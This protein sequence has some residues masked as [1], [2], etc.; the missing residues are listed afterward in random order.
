MP[1]TL[2]SILPRNPIISQ[3]VMVSHQ[4]TS[5]QRDCTGTGVSQ[6]LLPCYLNRDVESQQEILR[7]TGSWRQRGSSVI[8]HLEASRRMEFLKNRKDIVG[9]VEQER[10]P[11]L[12]VQAK[13]RGYPQI[14]QSLRNPVR[15][16][17]LCPKNRENPPNGFKQ[18]GVKKMYDSK[19]PLRLCSGKIII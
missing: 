14:T 15:D 9:C 5:R 17:S 12:Q 16:V 4:R 7:Q 18:S 3:R 8:A 11:V 2:Q 10:S 19:R 6:G 1:L 13:S